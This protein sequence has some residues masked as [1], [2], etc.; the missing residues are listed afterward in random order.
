M[1]GARKPRAARQADQGPRLAKC[2]SNAACRMGITCFRDAAVSP[3]SKAAIH[4]PSKPGKGGVTVEMDVRTGR[5]AR[6]GTGRPGASGMR[7]H[8]GRAWAVVRRAPDAA[9]RRQLH[10]GSRAT[11]RRLLPRAVESL[12][13]ELLR[14]E[15]Y[16]AWKLRGSSARSWKP[17]RAAE[18]GSGGGGACSY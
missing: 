11:P 10:T 12:R 6:A 2:L 16:T 14:A 8:C 5:V 7:G 9:Q 18:A 17:R 15:R 13:R 4:S 3:C 1:R